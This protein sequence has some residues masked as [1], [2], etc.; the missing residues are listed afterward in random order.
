MIKR[1]LLTEKWINPSYINK[2]GTMYWF[3]KYGEYHSNG[4]RPAIIYSDGEKRWYKNGQIHRD[5]D[6]PAI[7]Y[8]DG[9]KY[10]FKNG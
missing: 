1:K 6:K 8:S 9:D 2:Y 5:S 4:D 10:W 7:I 3:N